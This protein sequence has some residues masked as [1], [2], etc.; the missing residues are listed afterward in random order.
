[1]G[2]FNKKKSDPERVALQNI[3]LGINEKKLEVSDE[4]LDEMTKIYVSKRMKLV[5]EAVESFINVQDVRTL[6]SKYTYINALLDE[7]EKIESYH[8]YND[9][10]PSEYRKMLE[11]SKP[12]YVN[13]IITRSWRILGY[14][15]QTAASQN[16]VERFFGAYKPALEILPED[17]VTLLDELHKGVYGFGI[18]EDPPA[19][20]EESEKETENE[21]E[22]TEENSDNAAVDVDAAKAA[23]AANAMDAV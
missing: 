17:S 3:V 16:E 15:T 21:S 2:L 10:T 5:N 1:M 11:D 7:L 8:K 13:Q 20:E 19:E 14:N 22:N 12:G 23:K 18:N 4:F 9:P 6:Y